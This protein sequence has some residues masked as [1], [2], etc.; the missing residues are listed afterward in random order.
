M[1]LWYMTYPNLQS[2]VKK[3]ILY[4]LR[5]HFYQTALFCARA[6]YIG[7]YKKQTCVPIDWAIAVTS[8]LV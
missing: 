6:G 8:L 5:Y 2:L 7:V 4:V 1:N 3:D